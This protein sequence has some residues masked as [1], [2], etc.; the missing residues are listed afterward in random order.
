MSK[1]ALVTGANSGIGLAITKE[2]AKLDYTIIMVC[3]NI[4]KAN[5]AKQEV[6]SI[7]PGAK[8]DIVQIDMSSFESIEAGSKKIVNS[9]QKL[10]ILVN[11]A[12]LVNNEYQLT[13]DGLEQTFTVNVYA[14]FLFTHLM[15]PI[16]NKS[17]DAR[18]INVGSDRHKKAKIKWRNISLKGE[19]SLMKAYGQSKLALVLYT[20]E[21]DRTCPNDNI[22]INCVSPGAVK[23][24]FGS[25]DNGW[26]MKIAWNIGLQLVRHRLRTP[27]QAC[28]TILYLATT[29]KDKLR[30]AKYWDQKNNK[31]FAKPSSRDSYY[32]DHWKKLWNHCLEITHVNDYFNSSNSSS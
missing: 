5:Q 9:Y 13:A 4:E 31:H 6:L 20:Y 28:Q 16:L 1:V 2:F 26:L 12:G 11:N 32:K 14:V 18:I 19:Y 24:N 27:A 29:D 15:M 25:K 7:H 30:P 17:E 10:D 21:F 8:I 22:S 23:T 3:R